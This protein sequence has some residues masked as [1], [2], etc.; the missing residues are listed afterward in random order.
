M[1]MRTNQKDGDDLV[2]TSAGNYYGPDVTQAEA[3]EFYA[4]RK[5]TG[6]P[7][8]VMMGM[9]SR[10]VRGQYG[11]LEE[12]V[13]REGGLYGAAITQIIKHLE[14]A[15]P[16]AEN[17]D[18]AAV[19]RRLIEFY[20]TG[21]L[22]TFD[23]YSIQWLKDVKSNVDFVNGFIESY[24]DP[25]GMKASW[26][27]IVNFKDVAATERAHTLALNAQWFEDHSPVDPRFKKKEV[28]GVSAKVITA[29]HS[30]RRPLSLHRHRHQPAQLRLGSS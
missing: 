30:R 1:K 25:L 23:H 16:F 11:F 5:P 13:W 27:S 22:R 28:K 24:G 4:Q 15:V 2:L 26:E 7:R 12:N 18:Q 20:R 14:A 19:I 29:R 9:N 8:P 17:D 3:E 21:D 6:D 10:L